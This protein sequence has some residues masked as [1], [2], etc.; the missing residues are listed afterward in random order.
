MEHVRERRILA[1]SREKETFGHLIGALKIL[2]SWEAAAVQKLSGDARL[3]FEPRQITSLEKLND[4][5]VRAKH[6]KEPIVSQ[7]DVRNMQKLLLRPA[8][9]AKPLLTVIVQARDSG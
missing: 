6:P 1:P 2:G 3:I 4:I 8:D 5:S 9:N 7:A